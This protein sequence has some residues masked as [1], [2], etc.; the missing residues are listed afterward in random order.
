MAV[1]WLRQGSVA[2]RFFR[3]LISYNILT[4]QAFARQKRSVTQPA[5]AELVTHLATNDQ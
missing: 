3:I 5:I 2:G 1:H 4:G